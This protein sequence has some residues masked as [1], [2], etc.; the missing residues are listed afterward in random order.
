MIDHVLS[1]TFLQMTI[2]EIHYTIAYH[3]TFEIYWVGSR[4][5]IE[6]VDKDG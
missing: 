2:F 1:L 5:S 4:V 3:N 6:F